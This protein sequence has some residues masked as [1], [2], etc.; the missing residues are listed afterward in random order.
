MQLRQSLSI[1]IPVLSLMP[2]LTVITGC[3]KPAEGPKTVPAS[4]KVT[5]KNLPVE[6]ATVS[7]LGDGKTAPAMAMTDSAGEFVLT[8]TRMHDG[9][10]P[11]SHRVTVSKIIGSAKTNTGTMTME[12]AAKATREPPSKPLS[13]LP[14]AYASPATSGLTFTVKQGDKNYFPIELK[15]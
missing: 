4:G 7:F 2:L 11:G 14:E 9:A 3:S 13:M 8:T 1:L 6:G 15:D 12:D 10:V 5:Y